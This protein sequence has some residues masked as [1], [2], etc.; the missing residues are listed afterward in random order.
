VVEELTQWRRGVSASGLLAVRA[1]QVVRQELANGD[2]EEQPA[3]DARTDVGR[4]L[5]EL[6]QVGLEVVLVGGE[7]GGARLQALV[8]VEAVAVEA[9][10][11][12]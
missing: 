8:A 9:V 12:D 2:H 4:H 3:G 6:A 10:V 5:V 7:V 1:V 11:V